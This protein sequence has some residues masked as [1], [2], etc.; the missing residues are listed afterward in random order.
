M[1]FDILHNFISP[2]TGR[3]L[4]DVNYVLVGNN[5]G[6]AIPSPILID[7][8]LDLIRLRKKYDILVDADFVVGHPNDQIPNAQVLVNLDDGFMVNTAGIVS[9]TE[10]VPI[11]GLPD[12]TFTYLWTGNLLNRPIEVQTII[13]DNLPNLTLKR[14]WR[15]NLINR[16]VEVDDLTT[17]ET[18]M[19]NVLSE[20]ASLVSL[21]SSLASAVSAIQSI[22]AGIEAGL[23]SVGGWAGIAAMQVEIIGLIAAIAAVNARIDN[24]RLNNIPADDDVSLYDFRIINL[25]DPIDPQ[26]AVN[27]R[28]LSGSV[29]AITLEGFVE[30]G[31][32]VAGVIT[33][34]RG[35]DCLLT[36]IPA[37]GDVDMEEFRIKNLQQ[38]PV[39]N[40][41]AIS[42][43][44]LWDLMHD[45]V[46]VIWL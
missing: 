24:L 20:I 39:E 10:I 23:A 22:L 2:V 18:D 31:P 35:P 3:V 40:L 13:V 12:L 8:R 1:K 21:L 28:T 4:A 46:E 14:I 15:G 34:V 7:I 37:G 19:S 11:G 26:D 5:Q 42:A 38:S 29:G 32:P 41:D 17:L 27:L 6:I 45:E 36:N 43:Q 30:G 16:P 25:A 33:T 9:T 44:F